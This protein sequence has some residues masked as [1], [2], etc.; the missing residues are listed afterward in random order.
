MTL[1]GCATYGQ[2][3]LCVSLLVGILHL[4]RGVA[5]RVAP[6]PLPGPRQDDVRT[7]PLSVLLRI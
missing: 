1:S 7:A 4:L 3:L 6:L 5:V 2:L